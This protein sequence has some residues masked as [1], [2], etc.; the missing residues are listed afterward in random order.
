MPE[1]K[2]KYFL[3]LYLIGIIPIF[4]FILKNI[5]KKKSLKVASI[6]AKAS[7]NSFKSY[8][9]FLPNLLRALVLTLLIIS[10]A[11]PYS[12]ETVE[13]K[14]Y[15][16]L[17]IMIVFDIS[18]SML[19]DDFK[20]NRLEVAKSRAIEFIEKRQND[21][22]GMVVY[23]GESFTLSPLTTDKVYLIDKISSLKTGIVSDGTAIG[24][25]LA[26]ALNSL[27]GSTSKSKIILLI[28]D[29]SNNSGLISPDIA[30]NIAKE[31]GVKIH[32]IGIGRSG[33]ARVPENSDG[34]GKLIEVEVFLDERALKRIAYNSGGKYF[35]AETPTSLASIY[36]EIDRL[37]K[38]PYKLK[39]YS[40]ETKYFAFI[41]LLAFVILIIE[42]ILRLTIF[43]I[44]P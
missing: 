1:I 21:R 41:A 4:Y 3:L 13:Y 2:F 6:N 22:I 39:S 20:P 38:T 15:M 24:M 42:I 30:V 26:T 10:A 8:L 37:E 14:E 43:R 9:R 35:F 40:Q 5:N 34:S 18:G 17:D 31:K 29:G 36:S 44:A 7:K 33:L 16:G 27:E 32:T 23:A 19:A 11:K 25:G 12:S 28:S